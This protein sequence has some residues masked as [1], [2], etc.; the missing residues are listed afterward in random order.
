MPTIAQSWAPKLPPHWEL[1][2]E[3]LKSVGQELQEFTAQFADT[4][5]RIE[6]SA[7]CQLYVQGLLSDT[8]R[9][10]VEASRWNWRDRKRCAVCSAC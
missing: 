9:K 5:R 1:S 7:L 10:N 4:F 8:A 3:D 6:P 2:A